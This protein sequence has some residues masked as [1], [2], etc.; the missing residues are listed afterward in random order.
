[1]SYSYKT[2][3]QLIELLDQHFKQTNN[4]QLHYKLINPDV[5]QYSFIENNKTVHQTEGSIYNPNPRPKNTSPEYN[6]WFYDQWFEFN[7]ADIPLPDTIGAD[8]TLGEHVI[9]TDP[10]YD[11]DTWCNGT[12]ANIRP[13]IWHTK[14]TH[15]NMDYAGDR[16]TTLIIWHE[17]YSKPKEANW[18]KTDIIVGVDS[19]QAGII[20]LDHFR[21]L[22]QS[23]ERKDNWYS[24]IKTYEYGRGPVSPSLKHRLEKTKA[25]EKQLNT[26]FANI[27]KEFKP[28]SLDKY[29]KY[30]ELYRERE[31][32]LQNTPLDQQSLTDDMQQ[33]CMDKLW[34]DKHSVITSS[35]LGDGSY[36]CLIAKDKESDQ[37]I[38]IKIDYFYNSDKD[39]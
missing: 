29:T 13:G 7:R 8:I 16:T 18:I 31:L 14:T 37:I 15:A 28:E 21:Y 17:A 22:E 33:T 1:M 12:L 36:H 23:S 3:P 34:T 20:D 19:G 11:E 32:L 27:H 2:L 39:E 25:I 6:N 38:G 35:G 30:L 26:E 10:C 9:V 4:F 5:I 24:N